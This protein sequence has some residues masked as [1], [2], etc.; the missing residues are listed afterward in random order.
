MT[1]TSPSENQPTSQSVSAADQRN[2]KLLPIL[3]SYHQVEFRIDKILNTDKTI[4]VKEKCGPNL[5]N[6]WILS[7]HNASISYS[8]YERRGGLVNFNFNLKFSSLLTNSE[9]EDEIMLVKEHSGRRWSNLQRLE[10]Y[11][12]FALQ[13]NY[14]T[15]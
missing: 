4:S 10:F 1:S 12:Y 9:A 8:L 2:I 13:G 5:V 3:V 11:S 14:D 7:R 6:K 15:G